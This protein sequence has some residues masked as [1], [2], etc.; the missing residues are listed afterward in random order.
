[1]RPFRIALLLATA[2]V[3]VPLTLA[4]T[5]PASAQIAVGV[6]VTVEPPELPVYEQ[7]PL[8]APGYLWTPGYWAYG[9]E[10]YYWV[11]GT[12][13]E[14][15]QPGLLWTPGYWGFNNGAYV[16][17]EGYWG[18]HVG[19]YGGINY[20]FGYNGLGFFGGEWRGGVFAYNQAAVANFGGVHVTNVYNRTI[21]VNRVTNISFN[22]GPHGIDVRPTAEQMQFVH[23]RHVERTAAQVAQ[24]H[25]AAQ[26]RELLA[27]ANHGHPPIAATQRPGDFRGPGVVPARDAVARPAAEAARP[28]EHPAESAKPAAIAHP[29]A[30]AVRRHPLVAPHHTYEPARPAETARPSEAARPTETGHHVPA[31]HPSEPA[32]H[33]PDA[34]R[35]SVAPHVEAP[36]PAEPAR[37]HVEAARPPVAPHVESPRPV[38]PHMEAPRPAAPHPAAPKKEDAK[39]R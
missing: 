33:R 37:P 26:N 38:A 17:N 18:P 32:P 12:W 11:P 6:T 19:F 34:V 31:T 10:G 39:P 22:G 15:P 7:P 8:P 23:E 9:D 20:G 25:A 35:P 3:A 14:P 13:V 28:V 36:R 2:L 1:M 16:F 29:A 5:V 24:I 27:S 21:V 4:P 30:P